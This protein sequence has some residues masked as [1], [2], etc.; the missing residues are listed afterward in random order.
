MEHML[1]KDVERV[2][3]GR[4]FGLAHVKEQFRPVR[5]NAIHEAR[6]G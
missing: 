6:D 1:D 3:S 4:Y 2:L 5:M